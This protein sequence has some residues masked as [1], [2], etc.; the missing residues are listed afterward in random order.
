MNGLVNAK[1]V[2][3]CKGKN[4]PLPLLWLE[5]DSHT[6]GHMWIEF[7]VGSSPCYVG[8]FPRSLGFHPSA[9]TY[10]P[11]S[12]LPQKQWTGRATLWNAACL[13]I[14]IIIIIIIVITIVLITSL[15]HLRRY[16]HYL[17]H[18]L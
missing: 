7:V 14:I 5:F 18:F 15:P 11:T 10:I 16:Y 6:W 8:F 9:K 13:I 1:K 3:W 4:T 12:N 17:Q 2:A